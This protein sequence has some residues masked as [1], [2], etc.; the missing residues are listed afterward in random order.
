MASRLIEAFTDRWQPGK[1]KDTY[2]D[3]LMKVIEAKRNGKDV[4]AAAEPDETGELPD[5][6]TALRESIER[7]SSGRRRTS[8]GRKGASKTR[9]AAKAKSSRRSS[10]KR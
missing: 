7:S 2:R 9:S 4:H 8:R 1:Y 6:M 3:E 10:A 5:L